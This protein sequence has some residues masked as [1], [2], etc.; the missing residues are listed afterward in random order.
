M[1]TLSPVEQQ[2]LSTLDHRLWSIGDLQEALD[3]HFQPDAVRSAVAYLT[4][5]QLLERRAGGWSVPP[6][7]MVTALGMKVER[8]QRTQRQ[9]RQLPLIALAGGRP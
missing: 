3:A 5:K 1:M 2:V 7:F 9:Q 8:E 4:R 6:L